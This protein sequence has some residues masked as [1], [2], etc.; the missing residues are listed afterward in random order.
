M[1]KKVLAIVLGTM[2]LVSLTACGSKS[3]STEGG[4]FTA[5]TYTAASKGMGGDVNVTVEFTDSEIKSVTIGEHKETPGISDPAIES[6]PKAIVEKQSLAVDSVSGAT[7]T[8]DAIKAAVADCVEQAG[9]NPDDL[10]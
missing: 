4:S 9:G 8:S 6:I 1:K 7:I 5:G 3:T 10:K 2:M